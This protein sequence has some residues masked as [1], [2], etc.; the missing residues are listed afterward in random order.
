MGIGCGL[1]ATH[2]RSVIAAPYLRRADEVALFGGKAKLFRVFADQ[3][4][5]SSK[6]IS[7]SRRVTRPGRIFPPPKTHRRSSS[8]ALDQSCWFIRRRNVDVCSR[9][10]PR[11]K[12]KSTMA[13]SRPLD[14]A[15]SSAAW[16]SARRPFQQLAYS[17]RTWTLTVESGRASR[18]TRD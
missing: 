15:S 8:D 16:P 6:A 13:A 7:A 11:L 5:R 9:P 2:L 12:V 17:E 3:A 14:S 1:Q 10:A 18:S 4:L